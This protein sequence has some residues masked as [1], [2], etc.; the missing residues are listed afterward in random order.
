VSIGGLQ[1]SF[2]GSSIKDGFELTLCRNIA[3]AC[4]FL[5]LTTHMKLHEVTLLDLQRP[6]LGVSFQKRNFLGWYASTAAS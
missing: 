2:F 4:G 3:L 1:R 5:S 6:A